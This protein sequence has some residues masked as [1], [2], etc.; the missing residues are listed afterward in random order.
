MDE[1]IK[2]EFDLL[3]TAYPDAV[4]KDRW[5]LLPSYRLTEGWSLA[6]AGIAFFLRPPYP[7]ISPYGIY[8][9]T[10]LTFKG[11]PPQ[12]YTQ[13]S[14]PPPFPG[15]WSVF[16][17][18]ADAWLPGSEPTNGHNLLTWSAGFRKRFLQGV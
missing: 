6:E 7:G 12:N 5:I 9:P 13:A 1:R 2:T 10:G 17:W 4:Y 15:N 8:A 11:T 3:C 18:E 16:S 14:P